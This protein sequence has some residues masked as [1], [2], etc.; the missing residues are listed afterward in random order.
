MNEIPSQGKKNIFQAG[1]KNFQAIA[2]LN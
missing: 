2:I 1:L